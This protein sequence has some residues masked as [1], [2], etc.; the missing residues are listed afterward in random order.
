MPA[1]LCS[2]EFLEI[3]GNHPGIVRMKNL[4]CSCSWWPSLDEDI[5]QY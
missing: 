5:E 3:C 2:K 1:P 4:A